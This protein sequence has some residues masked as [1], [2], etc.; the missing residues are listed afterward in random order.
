[1][2]SS[3]RILIVARSTTAHA[4]SGGMEIS[5]EQVARSL[6]EA[7]YSLCLL[8]TPGF[9]TSSLPP[10]FDH[11][12]KIPSARKG[13]Y[14]L[15]WWLGTGNPRAAWLAWEPEIVLSISTAAGSLGIR[16]RRRF[17]IVAQSHGTAVAEVRSS[18]KS[19]SPIEALKIP[20]NL[21]RIPREILA[22]RSFDKVVSIGESVTRQLLRPPY[23]MPPNAVELIRNGIDVESFGY[24]AAD[25]LQVRTSLGI[26][27]ASLISIYTGRLHYQKGVDTLLKAFAALPSPDSHHLIVVGDGPEYESLTALAN[28]LGIIDRVHFMGRL[29]SS[30]I[31]RILSAA[32][33]FVFPTRR[34]EG[35]PLNLLEALAA[36]L[37]VVTVPDSNLP[38]EIAR[39][40]HMTSANPADFS[41]VWAQ[42]S[43][44]TSR[45]SRLPT[46]L[47]ARAS[48]EA[49]L[50][51]FDE[52]LMKGQGH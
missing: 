43:P 1:M 3:R 17:K 30:D 37:E 35:L 50:R 14:S 23:L 44:P 31:P 41:R 21:L 36:G 16:R 20:L 27:P 12:W 52:L 7:G 6:H 28:S 26:P 40:V 5:Y 11:V 18:L 13:R 22:Y 38:E 24:S 45:S 4:V 34:S 32:D 42:V 46:S 49:Y 25:R 29:G 15:L 33:V 39:E 19:F 2:L 8:T 48:N 51:V 9:D 47:T 10:I